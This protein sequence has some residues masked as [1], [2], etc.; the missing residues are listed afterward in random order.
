MG[1]QPRPYDQS[2]PWIKDGC[3]DCGCCTDLF[4]DNNCPRD[5]TKEAGPEQIV[6]NPNKC[7]QD[8]VTD[9]EG[10]IIQ[11]AWICSLR[12]NCPVVN[13]CPHGV[14]IG[15]GPGG[16]VP[17]GPPHSGEPASTCQTCESKACRA[18]CV[19]GAAELRLLYSVFNVDTDACPGL[20]GCPNNVG[21]PS[22]E[23]YCALYNQLNDICPVGAIGEPNE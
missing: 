2:K 17:Q 9:E 5:A 6:F 19:Y 15:P 7:Q 4:E 8:E 20:A 16:G 13:A 18:V 23:H 12:N 14:V 11:P 10:N 3:I 21:N 22:D 1:G